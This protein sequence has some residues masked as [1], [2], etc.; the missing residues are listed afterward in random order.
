MSKRQK[1]GTIRGR[2]VLPLSQSSHPKTLHGPVRRYLEVVLKDDE[3]D[4]L[5]E[6]EGRQ[7]LDHEA[8]STQQ[9]EAG[10]NRQ[11]TT[12]HGMGANSRR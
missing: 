10:V 5:D 4:R 11:S 9:P 3:Q 7:G 12:R 8:A 1:R 6:T 2:I